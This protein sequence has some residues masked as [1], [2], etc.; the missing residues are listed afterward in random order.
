MT[1]FGPVLSPASR[2]ELAREL[3]DGFRTMAATDGF[4]ELERVRSREPILD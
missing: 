1:F 2:G 3:W 4:F